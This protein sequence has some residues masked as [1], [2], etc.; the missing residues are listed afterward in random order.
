MSM[1]KLRFVSCELRVES[2]SLENVLF[3]KSLLG[4]RRIIGRPQSFNSLAT[5]AISRSAWLV[6]S[7]P[8]PIIPII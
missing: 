6:G 1:P 2:K 4:E 5:L 8:L 7:S 3:A